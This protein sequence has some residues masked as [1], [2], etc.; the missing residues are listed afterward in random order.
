MK[1]NTPRFPSSNIP[2]LPP[3]DII[4][5][6]ANTNPTL[7]LSYFDRLLRCYL[8]ITPPNHALA[9]LIRGTS[10]PHPLSSSVFHFLPLGWQP[11]TKSRPFIIFLCAVFSFVHLP[12]LSLC[13]RVNLSRLSLFFP[14][15]FPP[16]SLRLADPDEQSFFA[17]Q[18]TLAPAS[19][20]GN[21]VKS[22]SSHHSTILEPLNQLP[23]FPFRVIP[24]SVWLAGWL[25]AYES[26]TDSAR[27]S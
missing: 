18:I 5:L 19:V 2:V 14:L 1:T 24:Q 23:L 11:E 10:L 22:I 7:S 20:L 26:T 9:S 8:Q 15:L 21:A 6:H 4:Q 27:N 13:H 17:N 16:S 12:L 25:A 3:R